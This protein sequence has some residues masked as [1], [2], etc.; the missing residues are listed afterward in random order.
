MSTHIVDMFGTVVA[1]LYESWRKYN[2]VQTNAEHFS[3]LNLIH[4]AMAKA[5]EEAQAAQARQLGK[6]NLS[7]ANNKSKTNHTHTPR[8]ALNLLYPKNGDNDD[9]Y[10]KLTPGER[11]YEFLQKVIPCDES[12]FSVLPKEFFTILGICEQHQQDPDNPMQVQATAGYFHLKK[13]RFKNLVEVSHLPRPANS[14]FHAKDED[15][16]K[17]II[18]K[19][20]SFSKFHEELRKTSEFSQIKRYAEPEFALGLLARYVFFWQLD[21]VLE[22]VSEF[23]SLTLPRAPYSWFFSLQ[24]Y[25]ISIIAL[26]A[27]FS[28]I[29]S[30]ATP[31][32]LS[33]VITTGVVVYGA[34]LT[35]V[36]CSFCWCAHVRSYHEFLENVQKCTAS[37]RVIMLGRRN[38]DEWVIA[39]ANLYELCLYLL[40]VGLFH[41]HFTVYLLASGPSWILSV[42]QGTMYTNVII[43]LTAV[44]A[45]FASSST[46]VLQTLI[47]PEA[48]CYPTTA[49]TSSTVTA[50]SNNSCLPQCDSYN[51]TQ[52]IVFVVLYGA[53]MLF[54]FALVRPPKYDADVRNEPFLNHKPE[55]VF[56]S[57]VMIIRKGALL[58]FHIEWLFVQGKALIS[59]RWQLESKFE[60][61]IHTTWLFLHL[62]TFSCSVV[63]A[64]SSCEKSYITDYYAYFW[65]NSVALVLQLIVAY[66]FYPRFSRQRITSEVIDFAT[67]IKIQKVDREPD[68]PKGAPKFVEELVWCH[69]S[70]KLLKCYRECLASDDTRGIDEK[71]NKNGVTGQEDDEDDENDVTLIDYIQ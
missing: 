4:A 51:N 59:R 37:L 42:L 32:I 50:N 61:G 19:K 28:N 39:F 18:K 9:D 21:D 63:I 52:A 3:T 14:Q 22:S 15:A 69:Q 8:I 27:I 47:C 13:L 11:E 2:I 48:E 26:N 66:H 62:V 45:V 41:Q 1:R 36:M 53:Y 70:Y 30:T 38:L 29:S 44:L 12:F 35:P 7:I 6:I 71:N 16:V 54:C 10:E 65:I 20:P 23:P 67:A 34:V 40:L 56:S 58:I 68:Y 5:S 60:V 24:T 46:D 57:V 55:S 25:R 49:S 64:S 17:A 43:G 31:C 33:T